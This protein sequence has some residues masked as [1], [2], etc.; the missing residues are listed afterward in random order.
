MTGNRKELKSGPVAIETLLGWTLIGK[1]NSYSSKKVDTASMIVSMFVQDASI[2]DL[3]KLDI[4]GVADLITKEEHQ[5]QVKENFQQ[6]IKRTHDD[7]YEVLLPWKENHLPLADNKDAAVRRLISTTRKLKLQGLY[8]DYQEIFDQWLSEGII[9]KITDTEVGK[10]SYYL[11]LRHVI[12]SNSTTKIR[13]VYASAI[14]KNGLSLNQ[15]LETG[16]NLIEQIP[17]ILLRFRQ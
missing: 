15:C 17:N 11:P 10:E 8:N 4:L 2:A 6:T 3:W 5:T 9:E 12:K 7:R 13:P 16:P 1:T 14:E